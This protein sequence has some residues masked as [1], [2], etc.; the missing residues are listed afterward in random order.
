MIDDRHQTEPT[1]TTP[2]ETVEPSVTLR[3]GGVVGPQ[4]AF[5]T[6]TE[7]SL[8]DFHQTGLMWWINHALL[9]DLG[10]ALAVEVAPLKPGDGENSRV[11]KRMLVLD[12]IPPHRIQVED[13]AKEYEAWQRWLS[14]RAGTVR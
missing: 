10:L 5:A 7:M 1:L 9:Y 3:P 4:D 8:K 6:S 13:D 11:Y 14:N 2:A 12:S